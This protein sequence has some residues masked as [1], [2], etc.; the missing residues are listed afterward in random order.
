MKKCALPSHSGQAV[1]NLQPDSLNLA[2]PIPRLLVNVYA[3]Q[4]KQMLDRPEEEGRRESP[5]PC[6]LQARDRGRYTF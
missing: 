5:A 2:A 3:K 6:F 4:L 1:T